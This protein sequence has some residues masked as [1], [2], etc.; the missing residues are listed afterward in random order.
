CRGQD[1]GSAVMGL[2]GALFPCMV[3][4]GARLVNGDGLSY[5]VPLATDIPEGFVS[6]LQE[7]GHGPGPFGA[8][9]LGEGCMLP[10]ASAIANAIE[11]AIGVRVRELPL[12]PERVLAAIDAARAQ[13]NEKVGG[14]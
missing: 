1:E 14:E 4:E 2:T 3:Y 6:I 12:T 5:R 7:Q 13:M 10:I 11:D 8:K 9:S